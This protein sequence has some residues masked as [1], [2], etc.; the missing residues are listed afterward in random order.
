MLSPGQ[1][2]TRARIGGYARAAIH[3]GQVVT[4]AARRTFRDSFLDKA[5][6]D[7]V[8]PE[9]VRQQKA[10]ALFKQ[11]MTALA[12]KSSKARQRRKQQAKA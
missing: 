2:S 9:A 8:L 1:R 3:D 7:H 6:P 4:A 11:H 10:E 12:F 5:D